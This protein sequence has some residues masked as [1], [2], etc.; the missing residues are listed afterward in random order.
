M[1]TV[2][3][4][5]VSDYICLVNHWHRQNMNKPIFKDWNIFDK[6][7]DG[8]TREITCVKYWDDGSDDDE[9]T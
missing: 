1:N 5:S 3:N 9:K 8:E 2:S 7:E 6:T 4:L